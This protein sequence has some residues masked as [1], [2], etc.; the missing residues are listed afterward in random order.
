MKSLL[1]FIKDQGAGRKSEARRSSGKAATARSS[2]T[3]N[4]SVAREAHEHTWESELWAP[5]Q[6]AETTPVSTHDMTRIQ[7][8]LAAGVKPWETGT[9][10]FVKNLQ[11]AVRNHG[12]VDLV[13]LEGKCTGGYLAAEAGEV[14]DEDEHGRRTVAVKRMPTRWV[15]SGPQQFQEHYPRASE[16][17][18]FDLA[19][20]RLLN[21]RGFPYVCFLQGV[22]RDEENTFVMMSLASDGDLFSWCDNKKAAGPEREAVMRPIVKQVFGGVRYIHNLGIAHRDLSLENILLSRDSNGITRVKIIDFGMG[23]LARRARREVCGKQ[24]YQAPEMHAEGEYDTFIA[25]A[26]ALGVLVFAMAVQDYP[27]ISTKRNSC[28]LF[29]Y[30][31]TFGLSTFLSKRKLRKGNGEYLR[32]VI[33]PDLF[34]LLD[35]LLTIAPNERLTLGENALVEDG[36]DAKGRSI[37]DMNWMEEPA[38]GGEADKN[39]GEA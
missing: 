33:S 24:S 17:P 38:L 20:T 4:S 15:R 5:S 16:R 13:R 23:T 28:Q 18:W 36:S 39:S 8:D 22:Y 10:A 32:D 29:E 6:D 1:N 25:D 26:F 34:D 35:G 37:W 11:S 7:E 30:V 3:S 27:W 14:V 2:V 12:R 9:F 31:C 21:L 19:V